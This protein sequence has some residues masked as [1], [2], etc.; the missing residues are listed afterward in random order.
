M[1]KISDLSRGQRIS[2]SLLWAFGWLISVSPY[3]F[4][5]YLLEPIVYFVL[6]RVLRYRRKVVMENLRNSF[7]EHSE[8]ELERIARKSYHNLAEV[9]IGTMNMVHMT[10][11]KRRRYLQSPDVDKVNQATAGGDFIVMLAHYGLWELGIYWNGEDPQHTT[12]GVYHELRSR[13]VDLFY[14]RLRTHSHAVPVQKKELLRFYVKHR[15][16]GVNGQRMVF[17]LIADQYP[18][19][20]DNPHWFH[21][22]NQP[23]TFYMGGEQLAH[24]FSLPVWFARF[25]RVGRGRYVMRFEELYDGKEEVAPN[26]IMQRYVTA[27][28]EMIKADPACW[29]WSHRR[30]KERPAE[31]E[32]VQT[33]AAE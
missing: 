5:F 29:V 6:C 3:W 28:E 25:E 27:L 23:T 14:Q 8:Q 4:K 15:A 20:R 18:K 7:P 11:A 32:I 12:L 33:P 31:S 9:F 13:V 2:L 24:R 17:G 10:P 1:I 26:Q 30:W 16:E 22:L 21:F 19:H